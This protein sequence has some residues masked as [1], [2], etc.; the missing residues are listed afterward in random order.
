MATTGSAGVVNTKA[1]CVPRVRATGEV[2]V[3]EGSGPS[4]LDGAQGLVERTVLQARG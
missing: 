2:L 4:E 1:S 3:P